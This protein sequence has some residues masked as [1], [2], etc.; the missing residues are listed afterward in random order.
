[1]IKITPRDIA[2]MALG[3]AFL[4]TGGGGDTLIGEITA[5][6]ALRK[7]GDVELIDASELASHAT[8]VAIGAAGSPTIMQE[9][10]SNGQEAL[11]ALET[12]ESRLGKKVD[13]LI[14]FE[15][16]GMNALLPFCVAAE[17]KLPVLDADGM[18]RAFPELQME[19]FSIYG[20]SA[21]PL[22]AA[23]EL[24]DR[25]ILEQARSPFVAERLVRQFAVDA[26]GGQC[27]SAEH[28][29]TGETVRR[30]AIHGTISLCISIGHLLT[31]HASDLPAFVSRLTDLMA[32]THYGEV[33]PLFDGKVVDI[34][35]RVEGGYDYGTL[36]LDPFDKSQGELSISIKNEYMVARQGDRPIALTPDLICI[37]DI[38]TG[39]PITAETIRYGQR[40]TVIGIGA[41][42]LM[43]TE[44]A[45]EV[46]SPRNFGFEFDYTPL[47]DL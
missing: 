42:E 22:A 17:R 4:A 1:M 32:P 34:S 36:R 18:G 13:A 45:L 31:E 46:V 26:G 21:T 10:P 7:F 6:A 24:G 11:W 39:R 40:V 23:A 28:V 25:L 20:V 41:P 15:A 44:R 14:A 37:L 29:M 3:G 30:V 16:G 5:E 8:V 47:E 43:R 35:R 38:E 12:L 19:S 2:P 9:K 33:R 27:I